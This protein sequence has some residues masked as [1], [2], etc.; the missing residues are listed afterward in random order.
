V[1]HADDARPQGFVGPG[2]LELHRGTIPLRPAP[3]SGPP[4]GF[5]SAPDWLLCRDERWRPVEP[6]TQP[7]AHG[8]PARV[9]RLRGYG[10]AIVAPLAKTF[11][12][13]VMD[14]TT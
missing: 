9:G 14:I 11:I 3:A 8:A 12:E 2:D 1:G 10:N 13:A 4:G 7:L 5:W 6:G